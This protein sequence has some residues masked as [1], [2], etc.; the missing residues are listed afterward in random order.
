MSVQH[1]PGIVEVLP[2]FGKY[3]APNEHWVCS[4]FII[5]FRFSSDMENISWIINEVKTIHVWRSL[6]MKHSGTCFKNYMNNKCLIIN[7][8]I[9]ID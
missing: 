4:L 7:H 2:D 9:M 1:L 6:L 8:V 3:T 5:A